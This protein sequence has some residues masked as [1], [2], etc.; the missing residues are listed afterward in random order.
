MK[1]IILLIALSIGITNIASAQSAPSHSR[2]SDR[3]VVMSGAV[4]GWVLG[5]TLSN[6]IVAGGYVA[7]VYGNEC[8]PGYES[9]CDHKIDDAILGASAAYAVI[10]PSVTV[11]LGRAFGG[12]GEWLSTMLWNFVGMVPGA[13]FAGFASIDSEN[14]L[15][16][17]A[18]GGLVLMNIGSLI[19]SMA[20]YYS[21]AR[22]K[23]ASE[24]RATL[25]PAV[26]I[27][28]T[29]ATLSLSGEF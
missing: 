5:A 13:L 20:G 28:A 17:M 26:S 7:A 3:P 24:M 21:S 29:A 18:M 15:N 8:D 16:G 19:A 27:S 6:L 1:Q 14:E 2:P 25:S 23:D 4:V 10:T 12:H 11:A 22:E 9:V